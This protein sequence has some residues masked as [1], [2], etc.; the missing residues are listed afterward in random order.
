MGSESA[1][2]GNKAGE[3][4]LG[5][6]PVPGEQ[7]AGVWSVLVCVCGLNSVCQ[8]CP[9]EI[10]EVQQQEHTNV[11]LLLRDASLHTTFIQHRNICKQF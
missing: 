3:A 7:N 4:V 11:V 6:G 5:I 10:L 8:N 1:V 2:P 9:R